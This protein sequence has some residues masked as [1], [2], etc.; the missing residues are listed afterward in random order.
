[1]KV[2]KIEN[3]SVA[4]LTLSHLL[5][6]GCPCGPTV[7]RVATKDGSGYARYN[8]SL[9]LTHKGQAEKKSFTD[10]F[11]EELAKRFPSY[12]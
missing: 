10:K 12:L 8:Y 4:E 7:S 1:M 5:D 6:A 11:F 2:N 3:G 9:V